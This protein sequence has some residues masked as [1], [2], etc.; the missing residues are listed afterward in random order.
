MTYPEV[1]ERFL[2]DD[3]LTI[4]AGMKVPFFAEVRDYVGAAEKA[5]PENRWIVKQVSE[6]DALG[7]AM[8]SICFFLDF[9]TKTISAPTAVTRIG[10]KL[11]KAAKII[12]KTEHLSG[13]S[14]TGIPQLKEQLIL[15]LVNRWIY[16]D[17]DRNPND[18]MIRRTSRGDQVL[19]AI[20]FSNVDLL[21]PGHEDQ[22]P[23]G[24]VRVGEDRKDALPHA[25]EGGAFPGLW[26]WSSSTC[27]S[28][29]SPASDARC[30]SSCARDVSVSSRIMRT[31]QRPS[32]TIC[33][34]A[35]NMFT[36]ISRASSPQ[37]DRAFETG[38]SIGCRA[39]PSVI[40]LP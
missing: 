35:S 17:E 20:D 36:T 2:A 25:A 6:E 37:A 12:T 7:A 32:P 38:F 29:P 11:Y 13:T 10:G 30:S 31:W 4:D 27:A 1:L 3:F 24:V 28:A 16:C 18:Y 21:F 23:L 8:G 5:D 22:R 39:V 40:I 33:S 34:S 26:Q 14:Y 9:F 15:D 19:I